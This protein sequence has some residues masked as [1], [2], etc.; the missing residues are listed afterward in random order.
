MRFTEV[1]IKKLLNLGD[2][3]SLTPESPY[4]PGFL[5]NKLYPAAV[6]IPLLIKE[7]GWHLLFIRRSY[8]KNDRHSRQ[9]AFPGGR[10]DPEDPDVEFTAKREAFEETGIQP[11]DVRVLGQLQNLVTIT[12]YKVSPIV[13]VIPW[14]YHLVAQPEE[15]E[16]IFTIPLKWLAEPKN[17]EVRC[18]NLQVKGET[19]PVIYYKPYNSEILWGASGRITVL[20][21]E[22]LGLSQPRDRYK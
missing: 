2:N 17:R 15:V 11:E 18:R 3:P 9:V 6:L 7:N 14:P 20:L 10:C 19:I 21:L 5:H 4:P 13:G 22:T 16:H 12:G 8:Q 1:E